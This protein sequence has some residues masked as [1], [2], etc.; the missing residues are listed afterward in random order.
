LFIQGQGQTQGCVNMWDADP[1]NY[2]QNGNICPGKYIKV[3]KKLNLNQNKIKNYLKYK[4][5]L[6]KC[7][8]FH[9]NLMEQIHTLVWLVEIH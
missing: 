9:F 5:L 1:S 4:L 3:E 6:V 8:N 7:V 2:N